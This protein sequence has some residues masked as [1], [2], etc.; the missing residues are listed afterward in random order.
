MLNFNI[1]QIKIITVREFE[2]AKFFNILSISGRILVLPDTEVDLKDKLLQLGVCKFLYVVTNNKYGQCFIHN[3][4]K[5]YCSNYTNYIYNINNLDS[6]FNFNN[7]FVEVYN[8]YKNTIEFTTNIP[9][10]IYFLNSNI[11][12]KLKT[13][14][15]SVFF[16]NWYID[17]LKSN[18]DSLVFN[19]NG[20]PITLFKKDIVYGTENK[21]LLLTDSISFYDNKILVTIDLNKVKAKTVIK[22]LHKFLTNYDFKSNGSIDICINKEFFNIVENS[23]FINYIIELISS[24]QFGINI[25]TS[26]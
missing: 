21:I 25:V 9:D 24:H 10:S 16:T 22:K 11:T 26:L 19:S 2:L 7:I 6:V 15:K 8:D 23:V 4:I 13:R 14:I 20:I 5:Q 17:K 12:Y 1:N 3:L 18:K